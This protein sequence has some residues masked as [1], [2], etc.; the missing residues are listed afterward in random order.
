M[1]RS[2][3]RSTVSRLLWVGRLTSSLFGLALLLVLALELGPTA[4]AAVPGDPLRLGQPNTTDALTSLTGSAATALL[5]LD[6]NGSGPALNLQVQP[7]R[8][9]LEASADAGKALN[10]N[11]DKLDGLDASAL[12]EPRGYA[13]VDIEGEVDF[14]YPVKGVNGVRLAQGTSHVYCFDLTFTPAAAVGAPHP[15]NAAWVAATTP[16]NDPFANEPLASCPAAFKDAVA[17]TYG[18]AGAAAAI[19][20]TIV[21]F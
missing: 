5:K 12:A 2:R 21:F 18:S 15:N 7:G 9:P 10:L 1:P 14:R 17:R 16:A 8:P 3:V 4:L 11:A 13:H 6:N 19:N 20:F